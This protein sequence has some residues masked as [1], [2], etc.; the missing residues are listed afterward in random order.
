M[1]P[2]A[3]LLFVET[4]R[5]DAARTVAPHRHAFWQLEVMTAG[6]A[7]VRLGGTEVT[8]EPPAVL[9]VPPGIEH[10][11]T[12]TV[13]GTRWLSAKFAADGV[14]IGRARIDRSPAAA[15]LAAALIALHDGAAP[16]AAARAATGHLLL[17]LLAL[18]APVDEPA[19]SLSTR[20]RML[21]DEHPGRRWSAREA[22]RALGSTPDRASAVLRRETGAGLKATIDRCRAERAAQLLTYSDLPVGA[23]GA[24][25]GFPDLFAF[26]RFFA[27]MH[28][29][30]PSVFR[31]RCARRR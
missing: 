16:T 5:A 11:F 7:R 28:G 6:S 24:R 15:A 19:P 2:S 26:S 25:L 10:G 20:V 4:G 14:R 22:A 9:V 21:I 1:T 8:L 3:R 29:A 30:S 27:R 17:A 13:T 23:V 18:A 31:A 12:Y